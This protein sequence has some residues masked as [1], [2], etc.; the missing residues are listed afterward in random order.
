MEVNDDGS[1]PPHDIDLSPIVESFYRYHARA[2][3]DGLRERRLNEENPLLKRRG[4]REVVDDRPEH[5]PSEER[6]TPALRQ[7]SSVA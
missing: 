1:A 5:Q 6:G 2:C 4:V 7:D 3:C